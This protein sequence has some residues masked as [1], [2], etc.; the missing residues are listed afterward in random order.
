MRLGA[1]GLRGNLG[2]LS[3]G[4]VTEG[5]AV[6]LHLLGVLLE[7]SGK[8]AVALGVG[9]GIE[10]AGGGGGEGSLERGDPGVADGARRQAGLAVGVVGRVGLEVGGVDG[11]AITA[12]EQSCVD[13]A[14]IC[15]ERHA[16]GEAVGEDAGDERALGVLIDLL[17]DERVST[18]PSVGL[19]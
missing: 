12:I 16:L 17:L 11:A 1:A 4:W 18:S 10:G 7:G 3:V 8:A 9:D 15:R 5:A 13:D 19:E 14:G 6:D 2:A